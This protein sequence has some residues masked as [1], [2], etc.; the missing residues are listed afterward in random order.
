VFVRIYFT[1]KSV[2]SMCI[3]LISFSFLVRLVIVLI[4]S[5]YKIINLN[6][7]FIMVTD[8]IQCNFSLKWFLRGTS[9]LLF[10]SKQ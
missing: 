8:F 7:G 9:L 4:K 2:K 10:A 6:H 1:V 3:P 5:R